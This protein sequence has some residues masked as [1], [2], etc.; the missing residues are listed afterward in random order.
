[1]FYFVKLGGGAFRT[2][3]LRNVELTA[4]YMHH[5][6]FATLGEVLAYYNTLDEMV[7]LDHHQEVVLQ[8]LEF[9]PGQLADLEAFLK[10]LTS[11]PVPPSL[12]S[13]PPDPRSLQPD[14]SLNSRQEP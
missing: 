14:S 8:P 12:R 2:P 1:M 10:S 7:V 5:G 6:Q 4:P 11:P 9:T 3:S 13:A